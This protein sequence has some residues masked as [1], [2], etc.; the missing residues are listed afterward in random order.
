[1]SKEDKI[2]LYNDLSVNNNM[3]KIIIDR[4]DTLYKGKM[5]EPIHL[6]FL[7]KEK[8]ISNTQYEKFTNTIPTN[9]R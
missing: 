9:P 6:D 5:L 4:I 8:I 2:P 1:M 3:N 7:K